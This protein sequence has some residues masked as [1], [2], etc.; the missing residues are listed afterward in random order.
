MISVYIHLSLAFS[1]SKPLCD[2]SWLTYPVSRNTNTDDNNAEVLVCE[3]R[4]RIKE[5]WIATFFCERFP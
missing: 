1:F 3:Q 2:Q 5:K 4:S